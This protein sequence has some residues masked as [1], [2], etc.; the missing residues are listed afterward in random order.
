MHDFDPDRISMQVAF[1]GESDLQA[2]QSILGD[3]LKLVHG[4]DTDLRVEE[5][6]PA[7]GWRFCTMALEKAVARKLAGL[8]GSNILKMKGDTLE[9]KFVAWLNWKLQGTNASAHA[10]LL[11]D[12]KSPRFGLF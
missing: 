6:E 7:F 11:S 2:L 5:A 4:A 8:P 3:V 12:L 9:Q 10:R 1:T